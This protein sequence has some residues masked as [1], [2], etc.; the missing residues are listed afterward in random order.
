MLRELNIPC[1]FRVFVI[2]DTRADLLDI[3]ANLPPQRNRAKS[4]STGMGNIE[5]DP[6][7]VFVAAAVALTQIKRLV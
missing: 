3:D 4:H 7:F 2:E 5:A 1:Q 6:G